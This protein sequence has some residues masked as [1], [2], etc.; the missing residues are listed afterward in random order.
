MRIWRKNSD[1]QSVH[2]RT[3]YTPFSGG[4]GEVTDY[5]WLEESLV[6][7][8]RQVKGKRFGLLFSRLPSLHF[9]DEL[10]RRL[11]IWGFIALSVTRQ[12]DDNAFA[13]P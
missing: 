2:I 12:D 10:N 6:S 8:Q 4:E 11:V 3:F 7:I 13:I 9:L 1:H 5:V